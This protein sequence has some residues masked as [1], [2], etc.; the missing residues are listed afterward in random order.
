MLYTVLGLIVLASIGLALYA[1][2]NRS[3]LVTQIAALQ[4]EMEDQEAGYTAE[5]EDLKSKMVANTSALEKRLQ[6][7]GDEATATADGLKREYFAI[8][9]DLNA[10]VAKLE[11][12]KHI[13]N[14]IEK[15]RKL[16]AE[17]SAKLS[18]A[19]EH[20]DETV[21]LAHKDAERMKTR[22]AAKLDEAERRAH[23]LLLDASIHAAEV[24]KKSD[25]DA[26]EVIRKAL[27]SVESDTAGA[28][29]LVLDADQQARIL[30][31][32]ARSTGAR[33][34]PGEADFEARTNRFP[35]EEGSQGEDP[36]SGRDAGQGCGIRTR[37]QGESR[38]LGVEK[39][40]AKHTRH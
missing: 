25:L 22:I 28:R 35:G 40:P 21:L 14:V 20:A 23:D 33:Y 38:G 7:Q 30:V 2:I 13:P 6:E 18:Q 8:I 11:K 24:A 31:M 12:F 39:S 10:E 1:L 27:L 5:I 19:Q 36:E 3:E 37:G 26:K 32:H 29:G 15:S 34:R 17:I 4:A 9:D 16:D